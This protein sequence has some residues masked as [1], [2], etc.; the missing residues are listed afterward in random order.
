[1]YYMFSHV[2]CYKSD[3]IRALYIRGLGV[4]WLKV[5]VEIEGGWGGGPAG[6]RAA[7]AVPPNRVGYTYPAPLFNSL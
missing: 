3:S 6:C 1:M 5:E 7:A 2:I 4:W